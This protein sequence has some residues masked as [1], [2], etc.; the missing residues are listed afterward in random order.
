MNMN[1]LP[2]DLEASEKFRTFWY[3]F[4]T[5]TVFIAVSLASATIPSVEIQEF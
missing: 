1:L 2:I 3:M 4:S 5:N